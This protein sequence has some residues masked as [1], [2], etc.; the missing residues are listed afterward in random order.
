MRA[1]LK[2]TVETLK[3]P[4]NSEGF[5]IVEDGARSK[6]WRGRLRICL[7]YPHTYYVGM[8]NLGFQQIYSL[9]NDLD[10]VVCERAFLP[11]NGG[12]LLSFESKRPLSDFDIVAF[13]LSFENDAIHILRILK[14][15]GM[16]LRSC[17]RSLQDPLVM[18]GGAAI[19]MNPVPLF[20]FIDLFAFGD[21]EDVI[22]EIAK[23]ARSNPFLKSNKQ[24]VLEAI[25]SEVNGVY[26]PEVQGMTPVA[27]VKRRTIK[28]INSFLT[29]TEIVTNHTEF[30]N[31]FMVEVSR[32]CPQRCRFC[33]V[34]Y[35]EASTRFR[36][37]SF[38]KSAFQQ[39]VERV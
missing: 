14:L 2:S 38:L 17:H 9:W 7:V 12:P 37:L 10:E 1:R 29:K 25:I 15:A 22:Y 35:T 31:N 3:S 20:P 11:E 24:K 13:S 18:I 19:S 33:S 30:S 34:S 4:R 32:G 5:P 6:A 28:F 27:P 21:G 39:G 8:S 16:E 36:R 23:V 26:S